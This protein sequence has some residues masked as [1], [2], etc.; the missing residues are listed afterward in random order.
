[1]VQGVDDSR[2][3]Q[4]PCSH[5]LGKKCLNVMFHSIGIR[6]MVPWYNTQMTIKVLG[7]II[8]TQ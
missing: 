6:N 4:G 8:G 7:S 2:Y 5:P 3:S 1:M